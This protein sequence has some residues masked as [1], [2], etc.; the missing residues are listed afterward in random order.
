MDKKSFQTFIRECIDEVLK[1][2]I[3]TEDKWIQKAINPDHK[4]D[5]TPMSKS[6]C[7]THKKALAK[8][9]KS[10]DLEN[11][12]KF[13]INPIKPQKIRKFWSNI[14]PTS[15][16]HGSGKQ[17]LK[18]KYDRNRDKNWKTDLDESKSD[19]EKSDLLSY[20]SRIYGNEDGFQDSAE[21]AIYWF[22]NHFH[23]GQYSNLYSILSTSPFRPG[24]I[25]NGPEPGSMEEMMYNDLV[26]QF[27]DKSSVKEM[28]GTAAVAG[29]YGKNWVDP[30]P[31][32]K[33]I[34]SIA[35][36]SVGGKVT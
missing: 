23:S 6:S 8:R 34:K 29:F 27:E 15:R 11:E 2:S 19:P 28:T 4:G 26:D 31:E 25:S 33:R 13:S 17:D 36:K 18:P 12:G 30:D 3:I 9:F 22:A 21:V 20:L 24:P 32:R 16:I 10:A 1:E 35:S 7:T 14:N 5:C